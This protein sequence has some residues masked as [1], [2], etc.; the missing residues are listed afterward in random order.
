MPPG[1]QGSGERACQT[2]TWRV[3]SETIAL[4]ALQNEMEVL[5]VILRGGAGHQEIV[6]IVETEF[7]KTT[8]HL[9][10]KPLECLG[11]FVV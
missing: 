11:C 10:H 5:T 1:G 7:I 8:Q 4:K 3:D 2:E 9:I 6:H